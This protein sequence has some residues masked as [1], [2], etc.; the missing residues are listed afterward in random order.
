M[1]LLSCHIENFGK[2]HDFSME[3]T[4][5]LNTVREE[6]GWG[7][8]TFAAF[9]RA[10]FYG[11]EGERKRKLEENERR[12]YRP[13]QGGVFGGQ[14]T[15]EVKGKRYTV[16]RIFREKE[17]QDEFE[18][19]NADTNLVTADYT[20]R[21]GEEIFH[22]D[23]ESFLRTVFIGQNGC[24][25]SP[26][27]DISAKISSLTDH[28][29]DLNSYEDAYARLTEIMNRLNPSR[30]TGSVSKRRSQI[31]A[32]ERIVQDGAGISDSIDR[33][34]ERLKTETEEYRRWK[35]RIQEIGEEQTRVS[36]LRVM[37]AQKEEWE[38]LKRT[39]AAR[40]RT[41]EELREKFP[42][43]VPAEA[44]VKRQIAAC[45]SMELAA[46][47]MSLYAMDDAE[48]RELDSLADVFAKGI[49]ADEE[50]DDMQKTARRLRI[51]QQEM[52]A[53]QMTVEEKKRFR[54]L[55]EEFS[56]D[57]QPVSSYVV[58]WNAR[59][60][61]QAALSSKQAAEA[62]LEASLVP[63]KRKKR[64]PVLAVIGIVLAV[65]G[66]GMTAFGLLCP[67]FLQQRTDLTE[68]GFGFSAL[69][70]ELPPAGAGGSGSGFSALPAG[71]LAAGAGSLVLGF[72]LLTAGMASGRRKAESAALEIP[73]ELRELREEIAA[74]YDFIEEADREIG[75]YLAVHG[76]E[77]DESIVTAKLQAV[78]EE[79]V[80][81]SNLKK[82][83]RRAADSRNAAEIKCAEKKLSDFLGNYG[84]TS[85]TAGFDDD[86]YVLKDSAARY[87]TLREKRK[88]YIE[89]QEACSAA[90]REISRFLKEYGFTPSDNLRSQLGGI[91]DDIVACLDAA[92]RCEEADGERKVF[93]QTA[94]TAEL[95]RII[96]D[97]HLPSLSELDRSRMEFTEK[98]ENSHKAIVGYHKTLEELQER[99][100]EW[101]E[102][103]LRLREE[104]ELQEKEQTQY[105]HV[106]EARRYLELAKEAVTE[107]YA[108]PILSGFR[109][110]YEMIADSSGREFCIDANTVIT[111][112]E[113]G[114]QRETNTLSAGLRDLVGI[115]LRIALA[116]A[117]YGDEKPVLV[118]DD[119]FTNL[120]D[121]KLAA[122]K[123]FLRKV[124]EQYQVIYFTCSEERAS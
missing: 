111:V 6:N 45:G 70:A 100:E 55:E 101:E 48:R 7:K 13:W 103:R 2:L 117:M 122:G 85:T 23:R 62:A 42:E 51:L 26:T 24:A 121:R 20:G 9:V 95:A 59:N 50:M 16:S 113:L 116:D 77:F 64:F 52:S 92:E 86:L 4:D 66:A 107:R 118:M 32:L 75:E 65:M 112:N 40:R 30:A 69:S 89:A 108:A 110:Y 98:M 5:G 109:K 10:M 72:V 1:K 96:P 31:T 93:E 123:E 29:N 34:Q 39:A 36:K 105:R 54:A 37:T 78:M 68:Q 104:K 87:E 119:P 74:D 3:F 81:Y 124:A 27:D 35:K 15:F 115:C 44:A 114:M 83:A 120:D 38:R 12:R 22:I 14:L 82:K 28:T 25:T 79:A 91:R 80:E 99:C 73:P 41:A 19:R 97:D 63:P 47:R 21:L 106:S 11:L 67:D 90:R 88:K 60:A 46:D 49:F 33:Y 94:D 43:D 18:I 71:F 58:K 102:C 61:K 57:M 17:M 84:V 56:G 53:E 8:S 76:R